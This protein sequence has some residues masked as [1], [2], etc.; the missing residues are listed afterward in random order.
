MKNFII[1][2]GYIPQMFN[3]YNCKEILDYAPTLTTK[4][5]TILIIEHKGEI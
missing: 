1:K 5:G 2:N 4:S 3:P